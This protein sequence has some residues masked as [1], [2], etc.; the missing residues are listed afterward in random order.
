MGFVLGFLDVLVVIATVTGMI[1]G[2]CAELLSGI[3]DDHGSRNDR[4]RLKR[5]LD[6]YVS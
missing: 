6:K 5:P 4:G 1:V 2:E 3:W